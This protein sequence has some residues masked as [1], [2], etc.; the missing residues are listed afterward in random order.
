MNAELHMTIGISGS[1]KS[2]FAREFARQN[3]LVYLSSDELRADY[4][5]DEDDQ[6]IS[7]IVFKNMRVF[8]KKA[9][10]QGFSV[11]L[12]ATFLKPR[13]RKDY[14][15]LAN[16]LNLKTVAHFADTSLVVALMRN[17]SRLRQVPPEIIQNQIQKL[18][19]PQIGEFDEVHLIS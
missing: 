5:K 11:M 6:E 1:G 12:D 15:E 9:L 18:V 7:H 4:G 13:D 2:T 17:A 16:E 3:K 14:L 10:A 8:A 19:P